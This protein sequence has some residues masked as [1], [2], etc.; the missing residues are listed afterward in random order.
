MGYFELEPNVVDYNFVRLD[1]DD[2]TNR[3]AHWHR[4]LR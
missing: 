3:L 2:T 1:L 4:P